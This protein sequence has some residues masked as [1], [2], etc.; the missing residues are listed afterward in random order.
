MIPQNYKEAFRRLQQN[1]PALCEKYG[2]NKYW[3]Y[4]DAAWAFIRYGFTPNQYL[5]F[6][7]YSLSAL[8]RKQFYTAR[9]QPKIER[10]LNAPEYN[11]C[12]C[13]KQETNKIFHEFVSRRWLYTPD[14]TEDE[15]SEFVKSVPKVIVKPVGLSAGR[16][17]HVYRDEPVGE[18]K[19][20]E[21]LLEEF[22][23][24]HCEMSKLNPSSVNTL[25]IY[26]LLNTHTDSVKILSVSVRVG[27]SGAEVDNYHA[28]GVGYPVDY[29]SGIIMGG[30]TDIQGVRHLF[31]PS[32]GFKAIGFQ[33]PNWHL[34]VPIVE[35]LCRV[36]PQS[37]LIA[38]D[39][40]FTKDGFELIEAN[41]IGDPGFMQS[42]TCQGKLKEIKEN[43]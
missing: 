23:E 42:P 32:T 8:E 35:K 41:V 15:I 36:I 25:R 10:L 21:L 26:T 39:L 14:A 38:W 33:L 43:I 6:H 31:H 9:M 4:A 24:Q 19:K 3:F 2:K 16:G 12:F 11:H 13:Q 20:N 28:G 30:G 1:L 29:K 34:F 27:G 17:I 18:L 22:V 40:A 7:I 5:A 37:R